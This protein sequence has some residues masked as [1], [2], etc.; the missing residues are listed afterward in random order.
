MTSLKEVKTQIDSFLNSP[1][2]KLIARVA[3]GMAEKRF[4]AT[5]ERCMMAVNWQGASKASAEFEGFTAGLTDADS[6]TLFEIQTLVG[7]SRDHV[8]NA[9]IAGGIINRICDHRD[10]KKIQRCKPGPFISI[11]TNSQVPVFSHD[12][13]RSE[14]CR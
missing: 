9:P 11:C 3:P 13:I 10:L 2:A 1:V 5:V 7:R 14:S 8:R 12:A 4:D 6:S